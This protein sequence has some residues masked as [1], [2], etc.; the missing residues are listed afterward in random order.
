MAGIRLN[1]FE[2]FFSKPRNVLITAVFLFIPLLFLGTFTS[3]DWGDDFAQ[4]IHQAA[5]IVSGIPQSETGFVYSQEN[6]I[7]PQAYPVGFP[8]LLAPVYAL[9][10]NTM[11]AFTA[12][13]SLIYIILG[14]LMVIF[15]RHYFT[16][17]SSVVLTLIFLYNP[18]M[19]L[20]KREVMSDIPFTALL[21]LNFILYLKYRSGT[22]KQ[23]VVLATVTGF[24]LA[25]R[26]AGITFVAAVAMDQFFAMRNRKSFFRNFSTTVGTFILVSML[27]YVIINTFI[28]RIP[29]GGSIR[30]YMLFYYS[31]N[32]LPIIPE[33]LAHYVDVF[34]YLYVPEAGILRG[35][36]LM[37]G[38]V[39]L[40]MTMLGFVKRMLKGPDAVE[41]F[42]IFYILMLLVF[43]NNYSAFRLMVPLGFIFLFYATEG[44]KTIQPLQK[45]PAWK[46]A[47]PAGIIVLLLF[48]PG[49]AS[50]TRSG[51]KTIEGPQQKPAV[52]AFDFISKNLARESIVVFTKPRALALYAGCKSMA[53]P[54]TTDP[55][56]IHKQ[57]SEANATHLLIHRKLT[58]EPMKRYAGVMQ[59]RL[60]RLWGNK[61]FVL[62]RINPV[63][64]S[65]HR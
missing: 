20:F 34:R 44:F 15:Y 41:W 22:L 5:N 49:I 56:R 3:H 51:Y 25:V 16:W 8:L 29:S 64:P 57:V 40:S 9:S 19:I 42:F 26:P 52:E 7:G 12:Y 36:S 11:S 54:F 35:F 10:G 13:I 65:A 33:N 18:Q 32:F 1:S 47:I 24:M 61:E 27:L 6:Y 2:S 45:F 37:L 14:L 43:P 55:T 48:I 50:I 23:I 46:K 17:I 28:F 31:G 63:D 30:D 53:D 21:V 58:T 39:M 59:R 38:S 4:Y 60:T 62:Y